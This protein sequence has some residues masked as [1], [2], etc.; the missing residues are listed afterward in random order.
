MNAIEL[1]AKGLS[2]VWEVEIERAI[3]NVKRSSWDKWFRRQWHR[4]GLSLRAPKA[5]LKAVSGAITV[6]QRVDARLLET[7]TSLSTSQ[8]VI[9]LPKRPTVVV[10]ESPSG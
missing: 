1:A 2:A 5:R 6:R 4:D 9:E 3:D 7:N 8:T 10:G